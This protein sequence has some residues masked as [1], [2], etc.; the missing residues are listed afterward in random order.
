MNTHFG[1]GQNKKRRSRERALDCQSEEL[2]FNA[3]QTHSKLL[4]TSKLVSPEQN[5]FF[6]VPIVV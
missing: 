5:H 3:Q 4:S 6:E 1:G 2:L